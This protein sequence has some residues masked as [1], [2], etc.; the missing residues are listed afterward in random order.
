MQP[1]GMTIFFTQNTQDLRNIKTEFLRNELNSLSSEH[2]EVIWKALMNPE[3][4]INDVKLTKKILKTIPE[5]IP[6]KVWVGFANQLI[7]HKMDHQIDERAV[8]SKNPSL[9]NRIEQFG[10]QFKL[11]QE[12]DESLQSCLFNDLSI[13]LILPKVFFIDNSANY[14]VTLQKIIRY[15]KEKHI[16]ELMA[17]FAEQTDLLKS[18]IN[19]LK[20]DNFTQAFV[21]PDPTVLDL[22]F[23]SLRN[24]GIPMN[25]LL[26]IASCHSYPSMN[27]I[28][29]ILSYI[30]ID[31]RQLF[32]QKH[33]G[34]II[35]NFVHY[36]VMKKIAG[37]CG[38][39]EIDCTEQKDCTVSQVVFVFAKNSTPE[40]D[41]L[42][43]LDP[44][45]PLISDT[46]TNLDDLKTLFNV[47]ETYRVDVSKAI[48]LERNLAG[49]TALDLACFLG[50][51]IS[52]ELL[53]AKLNDGD[54]KAILTT[55]NYLGLFTPYLAM[56]FNPESG[57][58]RLIYEAI[59]ER[60]QI[61]LER[62]D[63]MI[64]SEAN[65]LK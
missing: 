8:F 29:L 27:H 26:T 50:C 19:E 58:A 49:L 22:L 6:Q 31:E 65:G 2:Q 39:I 59:V 35:M 13:A 60:L 38:N 64:T 33:A 62:Y 3:W 45:A 37:D 16:V 4:F 44:T 48:S 23:S 51:S 9:C 54:L 47:L 61:S 15:G 30:D 20:E 53:L 1:S 25:N 57:C 10:Q 34:G 55:Q 52:T 11:K 12:I 56:Y 14:R 7:D 43:G 28:H 5:T 24:V 40:T 18:V 17:Y 46:F 32:V 41:P 63:E 42:K 21:N 36:F